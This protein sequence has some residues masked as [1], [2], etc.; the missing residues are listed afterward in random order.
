MKEF[1]KS[2]GD[3]LDK[4]SEKFP[5]NIAVVFG[6]QRLSYTRLRE[7]VEKLAKG[8]LGLGVQK[9]DKVALWLSNGPEFIY[10]MFA[11]AKVGALM[12]PLN[13]R[14]KVHEI[15][16]ILNHSDS[17]TLI[18]MDKFLGIDF[19][20]LITEV[21]PEL[22][23]SK[24][25]ALSSDRM[26]GLRNVICVSKHKYDGIARL[27][28]LMEMK[29]KETSSDGLE[30]RQNSVGKENVAM[31]AYT[32]GTT[33]FP[34]GV[35]L[36]HYS[37]LKHMHTVS[38]VLDVNSKD[39][40]IVY[41]PLFHVFG[42][43]VNVVQAVLKGASLIL[44]QY[45]DPGESLRLMEKERA[46][47]IMGVPT[48]Y[49]MQLEHEDFKRYDFMSLRV[50]VLGAASIPVELAKNVK[51][52]FGLEGLMTGYGMTEACGCITA[53]NIDD[54]I[55]KVAETVGKEYPE[56]QVRIA[57][58]KTGVTV[59]PGQEGEFL[60]RG[61]HLMKG[62]Y[63]DPE[64]TGSAIDKDG[65]LHTGDLGV[66]ME[67]GYFKF[68][69][70]VKEMFIVGGFN[71]YPAEIENFLFS[72]PDI[73]QAYVIGVPDKM[74]GEVGMAFVEVRDGASCTEKGITDYCKGKIAN[75]KVPK[76]IQIVKRFPMTASGKIQKFKLRERA[77]KE[78]RLES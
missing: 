41:L 21:L 22:V 72:H 11:I 55:E 26:P 32:A 7:E 15:E 74:M 20:N 16:Y 40:L 61:Y 30:R 29:S 13:T 5:K 59:L 47:V 50:G 24:P 12:V 68:I 33:G 75:F 54:P 27:V 38:E 77:V 37:I 69:G 78:L 42:C 39:R 71:V 25:G 2:L 31:L 53:T 70:R 58:P 10:S 18:M 19:I 3:Q 76:Y 23:D 63:K 9:G 73:K 28:D 64:A 51:T 14:Y 66:M 46:S 49:T 17:S 6:E 62:Y 56:T 36:T 34:K 35:M 60:V 48:M 4:T 1:E 52:K 44:Q 45:F 43:V 57:D 67:N 65:W 8:L